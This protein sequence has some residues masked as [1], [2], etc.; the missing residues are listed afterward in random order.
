M[1]YGIEW[2][3]GFLALLILIAMSL[4]CIHVALCNHLGNIFVMYDMF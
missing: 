3:V 1:T 4:Y 2:C